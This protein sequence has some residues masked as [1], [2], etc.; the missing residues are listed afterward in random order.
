MNTTFSS[1]VG[2]FGT[3]GN[4]TWRAPFIARYESMN[5]PYFNPQV[6]NWNAELAAIEA[7]H[8]ATDPIVLIPI[9]DETSGIGS[10]AEVGFTVAQAAVSDTSRNFVIY[11]AP[12]VDENLVTDPAVAKESNRARKLVLA[13]LRKIN[14]ANVI[15]VDSLESMLDVSVRLVNSMN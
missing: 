2:L 14:M 15:V 5:V 6:P 3:C 13:H 11:I 9:T 1:T 12:T 4:S 10:L 8:L 7:E